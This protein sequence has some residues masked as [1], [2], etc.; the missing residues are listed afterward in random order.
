MKADDISLPGRLEAQVSFLDTN[1][2]IGVLGTVVKL[3]SDDIVPEKT[4]RFPS[5]SIL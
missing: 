4:I 5:E 1:P 3:I 2:D